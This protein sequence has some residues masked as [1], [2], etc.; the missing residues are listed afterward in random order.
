MKDSNGGTT[1]D[2]YLILAI[3]YSLLKLC[4]STEN[5]TCPDGM[6]AKKLHSIVISH[7]SSYSPKD[8]T[9]V[10]RC[11]FCESAADT[12]NSLD[13]CVEQGSFW[14]RIQKESHSTATVKKIPHSLKSDLGPV[15]LLNQDFKGFCGIQLRTGMIRQL[16]RWFDSVKAI[17][18]SYETREKALDFRDNELIC[19]PKDRSL[20]AFGEVEV[21]KDLQRYPTFTFD[22]SI[23]GGSR[24]NQAVHFCRTSSS[25]NATKT[26]IDLNN[27][28]LE[29]TCPKTLELEKI[30]ILL[31][32]N[33]TTL[34]IKDPHSQ[35][36]F[37]ITRLMV[38][39][40]L[41]VMGCMALACLAAM[42]QGMRWVLD[43]LIV[44]LSE[45][46]VKRQIRR[47]Q[48]QCSGKVSS[49]SHESTSATGMCAYEN[50]RGSILA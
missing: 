24:L 29:K 49:V 35:S 11:V 20:K 44:K 32:R 28:C 17:Q 1:M 6:R 19:W 8:F 10:L 21:H 33:G 34:L 36:S 5:L 26:W 18:C 47:A 7:G 50:M 45:H 3:W 4:S 16:S 27:E 25:R 48:E 22:C 46:Q 37:T 13:I 43:K 9:N 15:L 23:C 12:M 41:L 38:L 31:G 40:G 39:I 2:K 30:G 14:T 42:V